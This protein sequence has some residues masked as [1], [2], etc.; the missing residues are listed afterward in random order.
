[1]TR[2]PFLI[3]RKRSSISSSLKA[4]RLRQPSARARSDHLS[5]SWRLIHCWLDM[6]LVSA[7]FIFWPRPR[8]AAVP[9][10]GGRTIRRR[11][12]GFSVGFSSSVMLPT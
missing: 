10:V 5:D 6:D 3:R 4:A 2:E 12:G 9:P 7:V 11:S 8:P 1:M